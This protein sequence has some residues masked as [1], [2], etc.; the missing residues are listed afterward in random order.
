[1]TGTSCELRNIRVQ[2]SQFFPFFF[3]FFFFLS[4]SAFIIIHGIKME[5]LKTSQ[6]NISI[7][8]PRK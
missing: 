3:P 8:V 7:A 5:L 1:M 4:D 2:N 6:V